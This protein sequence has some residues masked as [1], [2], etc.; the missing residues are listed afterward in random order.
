MWDSIKKSYRHLKNFLGFLFDK[1]NYENIKKL[2]RNYKI[3]GDLSIIL[4]SILVFISGIILIISG[5]YPSIFY[6]IEFLDNIYSLSF[7]RFSHRASVL[8]GLMLIMT[9]KEVFFKVKR[10]YYVTLSLL[11]IGGAFA[12]IKD[13]D[14]KEG[15]FILIVIFILILSKKSFYRKSIPI[16]FT[17]SSAILAVLCVS[18]AVFANFVHKFNIHLTK[19]YRYYVEFFQSTKGYLKI[20]LF[21]YIIFI[22]FLT[23]WYLTM[24]KIENDKRYKDADL[25]EISEFFK[26]IDYGTIF[27]HLVY[28]KDKKVFFANGGESLIMYS[29]YRGK[30]IVLGDPI[31]KRENL[32]K[33]IEEFQD[34]T[35][36]YGYDVVFYEIEE[37]NFS[38]YHDAGY[39]FFKLGE[40]AKIDLEE[41]NLV[42]SKKS[43]FRNTLRRVEREGYSF[44]IINPPFNEETLK[45]LREISDKWLGDRK[46]KGFSLG[47]FSEEYIEKS[48]VAILKKE[49]ENKIMGFVSIMDAYDGG[50]TVAIDLMRI[51]K[52]A[53]NS[54]MDYLMLNLFLTFKDRG[55]KYFSLG[56]APLSNVGFNNHSHLQE[57][58]ARLV[59]N[60]G[61]IF[62]SFDGLRRYKSKFSPIWQPRYL[63]YPKFMSLP[64]VFIDLFLLVANSK[65]NIEKK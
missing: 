54:S 64:E 62:Y 36:L 61:N 22:I 3:L 11:I 47:W 32:Y 51:D 44:S 56:E 57:K 5:I 7:L 29:K 24:P 16:K 28:L 2:L 4:V 33:C 43:A 19:D 31:A 37:K 52:K 58:L 17:K 40:E 26:R 38:I 14:Y 18:V 13:L 25:N 49:D 46:E 60:S 8:I 45:E 27:S 30:I 23:I 42:G 20:A 1:K 65:E 35:D 39:Y 15:I 6:R 53:P 10:A 12:F 21:T 55:Y 9:S 48:P 41:F 59:Y 50:E 34:F 63:A